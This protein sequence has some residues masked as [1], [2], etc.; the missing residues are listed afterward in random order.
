M[1]MMESYWQE[2]RKVF[3]ERAREA[4][5]NNELLG[6][7]QMLLEQM[8]VKA[9]SS[10]PYDDVLRQQVALL[11]GEAAQGAQML[12]VRGLPTVVQ[13]DRPLQAVKP[14]QA[15]LQNPILLYAVL[16]AGLVF[17]LL[18]GGD[19]WRCALFFAAAIGVV[20]GSGRVK[21]PENAVATAVAPLQIEYMDGFITRQAQLLDQ[22]IADLQLLL[23]DA[24]EPLRD[25]AVDPVTLSLC[26]YVWAFAKDNYPAESSLYTAEKLLRMNDLAF[27]EYT[28]EV[29]HCFDVMPTKNASRTVY[30]ALKKV[31]D[32]MLVSKGQYIE[33]T[34][35]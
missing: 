9:L 12:M 11:F 10:F 6:Q 5:D 22:H 21:A 17:S 29:R 1:A 13:G 2:Q 18:G 3:L 32:G 35:A 27:V 33:Q 23:Q 14:W 7:Y 28:P 31:S 26:Q 20:A 30:P 16:G 4:R 24:V 34:K 25:T 19:S 8:K 15:L